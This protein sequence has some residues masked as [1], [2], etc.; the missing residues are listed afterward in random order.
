MDFFSQFGDWVLLTG[1]SVVAIGGTA[2]LMGLLRLFW[3]IP[4]PREMENSGVVPLPEAPTAP[5]EPAEVVPIAE[6]NDPPA[7]APTTSESPQPLAGE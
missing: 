7:P 2:G 5:Q 6:A 3:S 1:L 4:I